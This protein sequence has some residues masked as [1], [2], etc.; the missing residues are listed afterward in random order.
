MNI[1]GVQSVLSILLL[2][3]TVKADKGNVEF[4]REEFTMTCPGNGT[5]FKHSGEKDPPKVAEPNPTYSIEYNSDNK[6]LYSCQY[7]NDIDLEDPPTTTT[8][9]KYYFYVKGKVC[10]NC[11]EVDAT[12]FALVIIV[13]V[14]GTAF[15][16]II[17]YTYTKRK[18]PGGPTHSSKA[19]ARPGGQGPPVPPQDYEQLNPRTRSHDT[20]SIVNR[21]G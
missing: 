2:V 10:A 19:P 14:V 20:Y 8:K 7:E 1:M 6:G 16:M 15:V 17:I 12:L 21:T 4:W 3:A 11:F 18:S 5:W 13:D 9:N